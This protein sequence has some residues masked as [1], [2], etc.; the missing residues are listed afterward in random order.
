MS[1]AVNVFDIEASANAVSAVTGRFVTTSA[2]PAVPVQDRPSGH[3]IVTLTPGRCSLMARPSRRRWSAASETAGRT[4]DGDGRG[5]PGGAD[6][7]GAPEGVGRG[8]P[9]SP[10]SG[11]AGG[12]AVAP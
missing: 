12:P 6:D 11:E 3:R 1:A 2:T 5:A 4:R 10:G 9:E 7:A 8:W